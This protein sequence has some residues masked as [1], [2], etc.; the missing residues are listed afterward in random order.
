MIKE[1]IKACMRALFMLLWVLSLTVTDGL[2]AGLHE[3]NDREISLLSSLWIGALPPL[4]KDPSNAFS[5]NPG[6][7]SLGRKLFF[8]NRLSGNLKVSCATCH[9][10][11]MNFA[12]SLPLAHGM[13]TTSRRT[14]PL[15]GL[16]YNSWFFWDGRKDSLWSQALGPIES[17]VEHG[18][19]RTQSASVIIKNY[20]KE[21]EE[22]FGPL[23]EFSRRDLPPLAKPSPEEPIALKAWVSM[24][25]NSKK[26]VNRIYANMGK[27]IGAYVRTILPGKSR[28][29]SYVEALQANDRATME[30]MLDADEVEGLRL[31]IG[32]AGCINCHAGP[33]FSNG[34]FHNVGVPQPEDLPTDNGRAVAISQVLADE[35][36]CMSNYSDAERRDCAELR[37]MDT[38]T[39]KYRG[40]F[41]TPTL[42]NV[43]ERA[44]YMHAG[45]FATLKEVMQFYRSLPPEKRS[46]EL[47]HEELSDEE[48]HQLED[49]L[50]TLSAP[51]WFAIK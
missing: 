8:D 42:R 30:K 48:L 36:N 18:F 21:Y 39:A 38:D 14:M 40:A 2:S 23:P 16:G 20:R 32:K 51:L 46:P 3:W 22:L 13:G 25:R 12:D 33:L 50:R 1:N 15:I 10:P 11:N 37:F 9:P 45:Q 47:K 35:F 4:P 5:D 24:T 17:P 27:A 7:V 49:F 43:A 44:P 26:A 28:F 6:A 29:D 19:T 34:D 31:F 41:K